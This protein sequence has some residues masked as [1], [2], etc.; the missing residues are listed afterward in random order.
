MTELRGLLSL[1]QPKPRALIKLTT[2]EFPAAF[3]ARDRA[4]DW[5]HA[6]KF[7]SATR[8]FVK[9]ATRAPLDR[10]GQGMRPRFVSDPQVPARFSPFDSMRR[11][12]AATGAELGEQMGQFVPQ[13][14]VDLCRAMFAQTRIQR[15][16]FP[17][18]IRASCGAEKPGIPFHL[19]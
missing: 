7:L 15:D 17:A 10:K 11:D 1:H 9:V 13:S 19:H 6:G 3:E 5:A 4:L 12:A 18:M 16:K 8:A 14:T 2:V